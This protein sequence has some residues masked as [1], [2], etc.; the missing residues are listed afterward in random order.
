M[1]GPS[2]SKP[3]IQ[4]N[5]DLLIESNI[6]SQI[7]KTWILLKNLSIPGVGD[8][9]FKAG[10]KDYHLDVSEPSNHLPESET[11]EAS[12]KYKSISELNLKKKYRY[13][14][15]YLTGKKY[16]KIH[17][18]LILNTHVFL[19]IFF[20]P[21]ISHE[22]WLPSRSVDRLQSAKQDCQIK[23]NI[24]GS[25][26]GHQFFLQALHKTTNRADGSTIEFGVE[27]TLQSKIGNIL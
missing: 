26:H 10:N 12:R 27:Q 20:Q 9:Q 22:I 18:F 1:A 13:Y 11:D 5:E 17:E 23:Q 4:W 3:V 21:S 14:K 24:A 6:K 19:Y 8:F 25:R 15:N 7:E 16:I 2:N